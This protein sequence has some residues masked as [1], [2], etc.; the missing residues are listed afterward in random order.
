MVTIQIRVRVNE[1][2]RIKEV[3][4]IGENGEQMGVIATNDAIRMAKESG[5]DLVEVAPKASPPVC[6][7]MNFSKYKYEQE[8]KERLARKKQ[9]VIRIKEIKLKP[10]IEENDYQVKLRHLKEFLGRGDKAKVTLIFRGREMAHTD[11][12]LK[13][14]NRLMKDLSEIAEPEKIPTLENKAMVLILN[15]K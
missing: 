12:G 4:V 11:I 8:K 7:I 14:M 2:I 9:R 10:N 3:R 5:L 6:R 15:P 1:G 13:V